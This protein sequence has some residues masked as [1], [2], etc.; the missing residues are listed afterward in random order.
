MLAIT[1]CA[2]RRYRE[3]S[4]Q[5]QTLLKRLGRS[6][7]LLNQK[8]RAV[9]KTPQSSRLRAGCRSHSLLNSAR[10]CC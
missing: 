8:S 1:T 2:A 9:A 7:L 5:S 10:R 4:R 6:H 3:K